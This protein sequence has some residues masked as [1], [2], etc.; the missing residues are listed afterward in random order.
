M[1]RLTICTCSIALLSTFVVAQEPGKP[2]D[3][4]VDFKI[5]ETVPVEGFVLAVGK[6]TIFMTREGKTPGVYTVHDCLAAGKVH[7]LT[8]DANSYLL[9]DIKV[10]DMI[11]VDA[12]VENK[13]PFCVAISISER[14]GG[15]IPPS[16]KPDP[17][18]PYHEKRNA[19]LE[20]RDNGT[21]IPEH[22]IPKLPIVPKK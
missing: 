1:S 12:I 10:G 14:P 7:K 19:K 22:S 15:L 2:P 11:T 18:L 5:N 4:K 21:P 8:R 6:D 20:K 3:R 9:A 13:Q 16:Q 17:K